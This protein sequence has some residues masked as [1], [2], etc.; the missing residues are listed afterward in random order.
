MKC[1]ADGLERDILTALGKNSLQTL[2][3]LGVIGQDIEFVT[4]D[5]VICQGL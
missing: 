3:L 4:L 1:L 5:N 2:S